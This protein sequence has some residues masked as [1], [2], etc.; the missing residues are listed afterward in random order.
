MIRV[1]IIDKL[2]R[3]MMGNKKNIIDAVRFMQN[4]IVEIYS[5]NHHR[6]YGDIR[7]NEFTY[8]VELLGDDGYSIG[9]VKPKNFFRYYVIED[10]IVEKE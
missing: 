4:N 8:R 6:G 5:K 1:K 7:F 3:Q 9:K 2:K 10:K